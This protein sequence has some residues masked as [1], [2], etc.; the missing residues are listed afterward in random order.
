LKSASVSVQVDSAP[1]PFPDDFSL[2]PDHSI[3]MAK[4]DATEVGPWNA[5]QRGT[6]TTQL[7]D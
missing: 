3:V 4:L 2:V 7:D 5:I 6:P 1:N